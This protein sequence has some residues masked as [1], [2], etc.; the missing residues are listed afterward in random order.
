M[1]LQEMYKN[2]SSSKTRTASDVSTVPS[3]RVV[4]YSDQVA[5]IQLCI[6]RMENMLQK[7]QTDQDNVKSRISNVE[8]LDMSTFCEKHNRM[9][10]NYNQFV[11][12]YNLASQELNMIIL[13]I[14]KRLS[15]CEALLGLKQ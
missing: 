10:D 7:F 6:S 13:D 3:Q 11:T 12:T 9:K 8:N 5:E 15:E 2:A 14:T 4:A 1:S